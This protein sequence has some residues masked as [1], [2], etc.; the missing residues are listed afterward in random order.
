MRQG[1]ITPGIRT[2]RDDLD[3]LFFL[4]LIT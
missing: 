3:Y 1:K 4:Q 2:I